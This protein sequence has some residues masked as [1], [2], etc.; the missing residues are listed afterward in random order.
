MRL[1]AAVLTLAASA[2]A[3][4]VFRPEGQ[5]LVKRDEFDVPGENPLKFCEPDRGEDLITID[6]VILAPNPP[7]AYVRPEIV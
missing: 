5:S 3:R 7:E 1:S 4:N 2:S 6:E